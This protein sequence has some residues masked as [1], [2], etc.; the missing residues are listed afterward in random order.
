MKEK[1]VKITNEGAGDTKLSK[2]YINKKASVF[3]ENM[4]NARKQRGFTAE[5]LGKFLS[6]STAYVGLI[7]RGERCPSLETFLKICDFFGESPEKMLAPAAISLP[8]REPGRK[9][10][11]EDKEATTKRNK[12]VLSM[13]DTFTQAE[14]EHII[15]IIKSFKNFTQAGKE[16]SEE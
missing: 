14:L 2:A 7:E 11:A 3:G 12:L 8:L 6:I 1:K 10:T 15:D 13:L 4:R 16:V 9:V 5:S